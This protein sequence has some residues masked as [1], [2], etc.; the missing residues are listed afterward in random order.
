LGRVG[1]RKTTKKL[2][3]DESRAFISSKDEPPVIE[4]VPGRVVVMLY[5]N[6]VSISN[7][8]L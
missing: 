4:K 7:I 2:K 8:P 5:L 6:A 3:T 1:R